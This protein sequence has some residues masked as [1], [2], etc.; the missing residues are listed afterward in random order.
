MKLTDCLIRAVNK[1]GFAE[2][3]S[4]LKYRK[5]DSNPHSLNG[6]GILSPPC[7]PFHHSCNREPYDVDGHSECKV[8]EI[9]TC[10]QIFQDKKEKK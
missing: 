1:K 10:V 4:L 5:W 9:F 7:L 6:Q 3:R 2:K 8:N